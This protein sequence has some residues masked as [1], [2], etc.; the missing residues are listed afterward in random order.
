MGTAVQE[1]GKEAKVF[2]H[3]GFTK[4]PACQFTLKSKPAQDRYNELVR[5]L[6]NAGRL[7][8]DK[9]MMLSN[10]CILFDQIQ[11]IEAE[12]RTP[13]AS[14]FTGLLKA[15]KSLGIDDLDKPIS[16]PVEAARNPFER[17]GKPNR[18]R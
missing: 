15:Q 18:R 12:G 3:P 10:Y 13:R 14:W 8:L 9:H 2:T 11:T 5:L 6:W 7:S 17:F 4:I 1:A 16:A